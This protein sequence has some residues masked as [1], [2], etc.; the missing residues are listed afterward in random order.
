[1]GVFRVIIMLISVQD[2]L[3]LDLSTGTELG[4]IKV[5]TKM[6]TASK[7]V[8]YSSLLANPSR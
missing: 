4:K 1:M 2:G 5:T 6:K 3:K 7:I 8:M